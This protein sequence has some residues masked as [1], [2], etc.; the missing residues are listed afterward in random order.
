VLLAAAVI[1][2]GSPRAGNAQVEPAAQNGTPI[3]EFTVKRLPVARIMLGP[4]GFTSAEISRPK[5]PFILA[6]H[7]RA[8]IDDLN[9]S[10]FKVAGNKL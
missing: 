1:A 9:L 3:P 6:I 5:G 2:F 8:N 7:N 4:N 10:L